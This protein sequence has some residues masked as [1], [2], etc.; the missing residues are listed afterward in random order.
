MN[1]ND[2]VLIGKSEIRKLFIEI[3]NIARKL[4]LHINQ[5]EAKIYESG[6]GKQTK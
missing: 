4:G 3:E 6:T 1:A 5:G 2:L